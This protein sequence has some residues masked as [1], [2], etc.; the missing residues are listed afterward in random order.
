[1]NFPWISQTPSVNFPWNLAH[2]KNST[3]KSRIFSRELGWSLMTSLAYCRHLIIHT[4]A[5]LLYTVL[6]VIVYR[7]RTTP[8][9][10]Y[11][12]FCIGIMSVLCNVV[13]LH[14]LTFIQW[15]RSVSMWSGTFF[16]CQTGCIH[17]LRPSATLLGDDQDQT[18]VRRIW[19]R[20]VFFLPVWIIAVKFDFD[21]IL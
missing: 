20:P 13:G 14:P 12:Y 4:S 17:F 6:I 18:P 16:Q 1:M 5:C 11:S 15:L 7:C 3:V 8:V 19:S 10:H 21:E 2:F 9:W